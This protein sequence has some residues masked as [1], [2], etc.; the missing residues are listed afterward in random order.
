MHVEWAFYIVS[1][2]RDKIGVSGVVG[3]RHNDATGVCD[4]DAWMEVANYAGAQR[5]TV[6]SCNLCLLCG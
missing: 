2:V 6:P 4:D 3:S 5:W 1:A